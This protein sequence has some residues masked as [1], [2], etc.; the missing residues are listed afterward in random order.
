MPAAKPAQFDGKDFDALLEEN[1]TF[2]VNGQTFTWRYVGWREFAQ[3]V[4][5]SLED[6]E[7]PAEEEPKEGEEEKEP[8]TP[9]LEESL[10]GVVKRISRYLIP[11]DVERFEA[12]AM[13][14]DSKIPW[15]VLTELRDWIQ[16]VQ[17]N[18]PT[19]ES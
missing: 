10:E 8:E 7:E 3:W 6:E 17:T 18:L 15:V 19:N 16:E 5:S 11:E 4:D 9:K 13:S 12:L 1:R 14:E 2:R